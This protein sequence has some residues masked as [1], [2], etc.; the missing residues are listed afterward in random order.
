MKKVVLLIGWVLI[1][2]LSFSQTNFKWDNSDSIPKTKAQIY[3]D[4]KMF[5]AETW[6]S[7]KNVIQNDDKDAGMILV[8]GSCILKV[9]HELVAFNYV[10]NYSVTFK[11]KDNKFKI[12]IDDVFCESAY[13]SGGVQWNILKI[14]PFD[15]E[16]VKGTGMFTH[17]LPEKKAILL[18]A[19]LKTELQTIVDNYKKYLKTEGS[20]NSSW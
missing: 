1:S 2:A 20:S 12:I 10:Y 4:T 13:P 15:G 8:K 7:A 6:K 19:D 9:N 11:M 18:M 5:I 17:T 14:E 3:S 16:Y